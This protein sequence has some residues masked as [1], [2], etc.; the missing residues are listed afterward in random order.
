MRSGPNSITSR[1]SASTL[2][3]WIFVWLIVG[4]AAVSLVSGKA[5]YLGW[6]L[7][8]AS[9]VFAAGLLNLWI[10]S[11]AS[12]ITARRCTEAVLPTAVYAGVVSFLIYFAW[13]ALREMA[14]V[15]SI[16]GAHLGHVPP[17]KD[18]KWTTLGAFVI[19][20]GIWVEACR[21]GLGTSRSLLAQGRRFRA[22]ATGIATLLAALFLVLLEYR[23]LKHL[24]G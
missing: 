23:I 12:R 3:R 5:L 21:I 18:S 7:T 11:A 16:L 8:G 13:F 20:A 6:S 4:G 2:V 9:V 1:R 24:L 17:A 10:T 19:L 15:E 22:A 14:G